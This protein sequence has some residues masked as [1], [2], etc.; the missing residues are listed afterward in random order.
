MHEGVGGRVQFCG[1]GKIQSAEK[2]VA[3]VNGLGAI[4]INHFINQIILRSYISFTFDES[5]R[6]RRVSFRFFFCFLGILIYKG[7][8]RSYFRP[9]CMAKQTING[10]QLNN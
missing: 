6:S 1:R 9:S 4:S 5:R 10:N 8:A 3:T 2:G 7:F